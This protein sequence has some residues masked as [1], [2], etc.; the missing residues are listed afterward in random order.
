MQM[1]GGFSKLA[2]RA[3]EPSAAGHGVSPVIAAP[4]MVLGATVVAAGSVVS[5]EP[6]STVVVVLADE[7]GQPEG[8]RQRYDHDEADADD[9]LAGGAA[10][11]LALQLGQAGLAVGLLSFPFVGAHGGGRLPMAGPA[12]ASAPVAGRLDSCPG[13]ARPGPRPCRSLPCGPR[14]PD[15]PEVRRHLRG[16]RRPHQG[17]GRARRLHPPAGAR[18]GG[19]GLGD[20]QG[21]RQPHRPG[22]RGVV[23]PARPGDGHAPDHRRAQ[24]H[25]ARLHGPGRPRHRRRLLHRQPG[26]HHH[27]QRPRQGQDPRGQGRPGPGGPRRGQGL[28]GGGLP[29][30]VDREGD[31]DHGPGGVGPH[32]RGAGRRL[33]R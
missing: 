27:R 7:A 18:P 12:R 30:R 14:G 25:G 15:R 28:R 11:L 1:G 9:H 29:G 23:H 2:A 16:R 33:S 32:G 22:Q 21:D 13:R 8:R 20:G 19:R 3:L 26:R 4:G 5:V 10:P 17:R 31:H 6:A 24:E